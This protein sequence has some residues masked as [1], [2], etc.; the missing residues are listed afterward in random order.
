[1][2]GIA[3]AAQGTHSAGK[4]EGIIDVKEAYSVGDWALVKRW[5]ELC[6]FD[7]SKTKCSSTGW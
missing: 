1:M 2:K 5:K 7:G 4:S 3:F 6:H